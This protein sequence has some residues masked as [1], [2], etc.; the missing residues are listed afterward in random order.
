MRPDRRWLI[1][2]VVLLAAAVLVGVLAVVKSDPQEQARHGGGPTR[3]PPLSG[4]PTPLP[5]TSAPPTTTRP[6]ATATATRPPTRPR[7]RGAVR[8]PAPRGSGSSPRPSTRAST[9]PSTTSTGST[10]APPWCGR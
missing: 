2:G 5:L 6:T 3:T 8:R 7:R 10:T 4:T 1:I 9:C